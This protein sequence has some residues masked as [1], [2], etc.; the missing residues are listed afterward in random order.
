MNVDIRVIVDVTEGEIDL[1]MTNNDDSFVVFTNHSNG[2]HEILLDSKYQ[3]LPDDTDDTLSVTPQTTKRS[4]DNA[5]APLPP[6]SQTF[7][8]VDRFAG[9]ALATHITLKQA[10]M[11]LRVFG[12]K[13]RLVVTLPQNVHNL[14]GT[15]FFLAIRAVGHAKVTSG[16]VYFR[17]DQLH[18][19][20]FVFFSVFFSCFFLFLAVCVVIWKAKQADDLRRAR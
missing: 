13:N 20:L 3:W 12:M 15:R 1:Q 19:D 7:R 11:L 4:S 10:S 5:G 9:D 6:S 14:S 17:Q 8:V 18:I 2:D 16:I